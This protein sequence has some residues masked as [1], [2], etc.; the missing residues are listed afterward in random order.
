MIA[1]KKIVLSGCLIAT[2]LSTLTLASSKPMDTVPARPESQV[3]L[4][5]YSTQPYNSWAFRNV[6]INPS[7]MVPRGGD[8][9]A[10]PTAINPEVGLFKFEYAGKSYTVREAMIGDDT[11]GFIVLKDGKIIYEEYFEGF[12]EKD[13]H[14][15]AS[16]TKSLVGLSMG[17]LV[18]QGK[19]KVDQTVETVIPELKGSYFGSRSIREVVNMVSALDYSEDYVNMEPGAVSTE[20]FRRIGFIPAFDLMALD[21]VQDSTPR[22]V[23]NYLPMFQK[24]PDL[25]PNWKYEYHS[26]NVDVAGWIIS[27]VSGLP[28]QTFVAENVWSKLGVEH[29]AFFMADVSFNA[30]ATGGFNTTLR[31]F[32]RVGLAVVNNGRFNNHQIFPEKWIKETFTLTKDEQLHME[33]SVYKEE[34]SN[35]YDEWLS[36]YKNYLWVHDTEKRIGTFRGVFGQNLYINQEKNLVI[37][38]FSSAAT[39]S[40]GA[41]VTNKPRMAAFEAIASQLK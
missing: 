20:Y 27:R 8:I 18:E 17:I 19:L 37:A 7:L 31:D 12:T 26:P 9:V 25:E 13:H 15:W 5:N 3:T 24:N 23:I 34:S 22:G 41:R 35:V 21:P 33:R 29:D 30:I 2:F 14:M 4:M 32:A 40:N 16:C 6:G 10:L 38:T 1:G 28:L 39:A 36:G 11:D